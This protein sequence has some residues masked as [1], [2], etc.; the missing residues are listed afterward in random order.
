[1]ELGEALLRVGDFERR[2][3]DPAV[4][5]PSVWVVGSRWADIVER[6]AASGDRSLQLVRGPE[7]TSDVIVRTAA[8]VPIPAAELVVPA[9]GA[10][11]T[12]PP[13][14]IEAMVRVEGERDLLAI[15]LVAYTFSDV[16]PVRAPV[17]AITG[18]VDVPLTVSAS[19]R[20]EPVRV[21]VPPELIDPP[22]GPRPNYLLPYLVMRPSRVATT[23]AWVD[24]L[25]IIAWRRPSHLGEG[26][27]V[28]DRV[29]G[30]DGELALEL[31]LDP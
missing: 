8:R 24:D 17:S 6:H 11:T 10:P 20:W 19:G 26:F 9:I 4:D 25:E 3:G 1:V 31:L 21:A 7:H 23:V 22:A 27:A 12:V 18:T 14:E 2:G 13:L 28:I 15:R 5:D 29:R 30:V 16:D